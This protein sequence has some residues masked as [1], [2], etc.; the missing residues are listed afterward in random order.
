MSSW[1][2]LRQNINRWSNK[3]NAAVDDLADQAALQ[4]K[5]SARRGD[6][7]KEY[8]NLGKLTYQ[9]LSPAVLEDATATTA[10]APDTLTEQI[11]SAISRITAIQAE[12][13]E[14]ETRLKQASGKHE[15]T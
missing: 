2:N 12:I 4:F 3:I 11:N 14:L 15:T 6:L 7:D 1:D 8:A 5:L 9:K 13:E 10:D